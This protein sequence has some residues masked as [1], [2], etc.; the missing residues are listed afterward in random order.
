MVPIGCMFP[1]GGDTAPTGA[2]W[3]LCNGASL[4]TSTYGDLFGVI[5]YKFGGSAGAMLLPNLQGKMLLGVWPDNEDDTVND[6]DCNI[7]GEIGGTTDPPIKAHTHGIN[8]THPASTSGNQSVNHTHDIDHNHPSFNTSSIPSH[9]HDG[10]FINT[11]VPVS[12]T[13]LPIF[14]A[15][16]ATSY[17]G[18]AQLQAGGGADGATAMT[19]DIPVTSGLTSGNQSPTNHTHTT[20][21]LA[22]TGASG[23][24][25]ET[26]AT[27]YRPPYVTV[28]F[29]IRIA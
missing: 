25:I 11:H 9:T 16:T 23:A 24:V 7:V 19:I 12:G 18:S 21:A 1:Y 26:V 10:H 5:G 22:H 4:S 8:H 27:K 2:I 14:V 6:A 29:I 3:A 17:S 15:S 28:S 13:A 20:P